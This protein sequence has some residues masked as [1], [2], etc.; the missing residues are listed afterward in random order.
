MAA[1][2]KKYFFK[3]Y[4]TGIRSYILMHHMSKGSRRFRECQTLYISAKK[5]QLGCM[6]SK[7][8]NKNQRISNC[9]K[10]KESPVL[11]LWAA[12]ISDYWREIRL[13]FHTRAFGRCYP[14][15]SLLSHDPITIQRKVYRFVK[16]SLY[17]FN[18][19]SY[20]KMFFFIFKKLLFKE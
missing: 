8:L 18:S 7:F 12:F 14:S 16:S 1:H 19:Y 17:Y 10:L 3:L 9:V 11:Q 2:S 4:Y 5:L 13:G 15:V 6:K 20:L